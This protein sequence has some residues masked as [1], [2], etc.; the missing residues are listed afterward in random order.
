MPLGDDGFRA[1]CQPGCAP[2]R[3]FDEDTWRVFADRLHY[4]AADAGQAADWQHIA[5]AV[6]ALCERYGAGGNTLFY[7][8]VAP[9]LYEPIIENLG[10]SGLVKGGPAW[11]QAR[12]GTVSTKPGVV[13]GM[14]THPEMTA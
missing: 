13:R 5:A 4:H 14:N 2:R 10:A 11:C 6:Q 8:S 3:G 12:P 1:R 9:D 7:L